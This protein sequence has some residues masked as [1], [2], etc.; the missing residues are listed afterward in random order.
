V[1]T[2]IK[3]EI[4]LL[5]VGNKSDLSDQRAISMKEVKQFAKDFNLHY[6][7]TSAKTG[8]SVDDCFYVLTC[9]MVGLDVPELKLS[10]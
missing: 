10:I 5:L 7:E 8:E 1:R 4:P 3:F 2:N 9:L 6:I